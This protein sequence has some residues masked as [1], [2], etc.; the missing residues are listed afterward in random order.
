ME[1]VRRGGAL[2]GGAHGEGGLHGRVLRFLGV[3]GGWNAWREAA[4]GAMRPPRDM[5]G[6]S[7]SGDLPAF[8]A[9]WGLVAGCG[10]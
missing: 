7:R 4:Q 5:A 9:R 10:W 3:A 8:S 2:H 6:A 1:R